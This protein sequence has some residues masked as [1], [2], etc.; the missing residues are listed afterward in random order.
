[1]ENAKEIRWG[2]LG[3]GD[4]CE[5]KSGPAFNKVNHS[6]LVAVMRRDG[7]KAKDFASRHGVSKYY[8][9]A[10]DLIADSAINAVY[11]ATPPSYHEDY[12]IR[13][14]TAGKPVYI[15]KPVALNSASCERILSASKRL[16]VKAS[17]A[18]Y[19]RGLPVFKK[20]KILLDSGTIGK[21][22]LIIAHTLQAPSPKMQTEDYWRTSPE[23]SGGGLFFD[24]SPHQLDIFYW[25]FGKP[26]KVRGSSINQRRRYQAPDLTTVDALFEQG[27]YLHG[28]W[29]FNVNA[30]SEEEICEII[31]DLGKIT[32]S[33]FR[34]SDI[35][36]TT[37]KGTEII[38]LD[39]PENIQQ[40]MI[41]EVVKF[42]RGEGPNPCSL[43]DALVTMRI[44]DSTVSDET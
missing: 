17:V 38:T 10:D 9:D 44:M 43:E 37:D 6:S 23:I 18:H 19:R 29:A 24:L 40:P 31:G 34:K 11:V 3:C 12:A 22:S 20:I 42:F 27:V 30:A 21:P 2:I 5:V 15:E 1:M 33:F 32:F 39:Y 35:V 26:I 41:D 8:D 13:A 7:E 36:I 14:M 16:G 4:V 28:V 25:L